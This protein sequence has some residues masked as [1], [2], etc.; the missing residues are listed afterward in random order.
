MRSVQA[1]RIRMKKRNNNSEKVYLLLIFYSYMALLFSKF[2]LFFNSENF[3]V[4]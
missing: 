2:T 4:Y 1:Q 3:V